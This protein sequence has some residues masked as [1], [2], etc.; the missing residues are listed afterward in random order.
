MQNHT[1]YK[2]FAQKFAYVNKKEY[3]C[4]KFQENLCFCFIF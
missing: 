2:I 3:L 4:R 1:F